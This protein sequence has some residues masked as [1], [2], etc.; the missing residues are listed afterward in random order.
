VNDGFL[1]EVRHGGHD[2]IPL[3]DPLLHPMHSIDNSC[4]GS[5]MYS[6]R[7]MDASS[8]LLSGGMFGV[9][10]ASIFMTTMTS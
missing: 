3:K 5:R 1:I 9:R 6:T 2:A 7:C 4:F 8:H 10:N